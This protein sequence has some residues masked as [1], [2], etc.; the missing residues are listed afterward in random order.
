MSHR[1]FCLAK[2]V[3]FKKI[4]NFA[5]CSRLPCETVFKLDVLLD[6][7]T[8]Q[9]PTNKAIV[10]CTSKGSIF[11]EWFSAPRIIKSVSNTRTSSGRNWQNNTSS[12]SGI[13]IAPVVQIIGCYCEKKRLHTTFAKQVLHGCWA[14]VQCKPMTT[15][16]LRAAASTLLFRTTDDLREAEYHYCYHQRTLSQCSVLTNNITFCIW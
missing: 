2:S 14:A 3:F 9:A 5:R 12:V 13:I 4:I 1:G 8:F 6:L 16:F 7:L 10:N 15:A 11:T